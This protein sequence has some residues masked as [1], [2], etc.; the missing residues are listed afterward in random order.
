MILELNGKKYQT[1]FI[2]ARLYRQAVEIVKEHDL[3]NI[4]TETMDYIV[5]F[6]VK[7]FNNQFSIDDLYDYLPA[8]DLEEIIAEALTTATQPK[9]SKK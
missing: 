9:N 8:E 5:G 6:I 3:N 2:S 4:S 7:L 1:D